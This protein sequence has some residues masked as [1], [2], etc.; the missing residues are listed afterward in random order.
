MGPFSTTAGLVGV[1]IFAGDAV[2]C[3]TD[4]GSVSGDDRG[5][6]VGALG[7]ELL[8]LGLNHYSTSRIVAFGRFLPEAI[9]RLHRVVQGLSSPFVGLVV[10]FS[11]Y[12]H[13][14]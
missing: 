13:A 11:A 12:D 8:A 3:G 9:L 6:T 4:L 2:F 7:V 5:E 14:S 10:P 1:V